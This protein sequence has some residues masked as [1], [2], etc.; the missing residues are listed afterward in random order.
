LLLWLPGLATPTAIMV[1]T[2]VGAGHG[3]LMKGGE[4]LEIASKANTV[5]FDKTGTLTVGKPAVTDFT[6]VASDEFI[7]SLMNQQSEQHIPVDDYLVWI[8]GSLERNSEHVL[9]TAIVKYSERKIEDLL[10]TKPFTQ[11]SN[12][13]ALTGRG[14]S[15]MIDG[16]IAV[17]IGNRAFA[18]RESMTLTPEVEQYMR[19]LEFE[20]KTAIVA[21]INGTVCAVLGVADEVKDEAADSVRYLKKMG[22]DIWMIT[23]DSTRTA[24]AIARQLDIPTDRV[25]AEA[26]PH[27]KVELV[28]KLQSD[29]KIVAMVGDGVNDSPALA[30]A[31]VGIS[32]GT[33]AEIANEA[34]DMVLVSGKVAGTC[35]ALHLS[36][37][38]F[39]RIQLNFLFSMIYNVLSIPLAAG[40]FFP[41][42]HTRLPPTVA[43]VAMA[44]SS[45]SVVCSSLALRLYKPPNVLAAESLTLRQR[46]PQILRLGD[47][48]SRQEYSFL[49]QQDSNSEPTMTEEE[50]TLE[51]RDEI[52]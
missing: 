18:E 45:V 28:R 6:R 12:F 17:A 37:V 16:K 9:A 27:S 50:E 40:V 38:I 42:L 1:G 35:T 47:R 22:M 3:V 43:A 51:F 48:K 41:I 15:G 7:T 31:D 30:E 44:L 32:M 8:L 2:G 14:A 26:L 23:G 29:G 52:V 19:S 20:G 46:L 4:T 34:S 36:R 10:E 5:L 24:H 25:V 21:G 33:G 11:P 49:T 39:R 13:V